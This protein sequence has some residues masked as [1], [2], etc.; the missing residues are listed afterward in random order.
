VTAVTIYPVCV[1]RLYRCGVR[2]PAY[3]RLYYNFIIVILSV[4]S[5]TSLV[6]DTEHGL[7]TVVRTYTFVMIHCKFIL[8]ILVIE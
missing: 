5:V 3:R 1:Y 4:W 2:Y 7:S 8:N 6:R